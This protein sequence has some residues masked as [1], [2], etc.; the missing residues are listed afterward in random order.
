MGSDSKVK[1][2]G[3]H[4]S[5]ESTRLKVLEELHRLKEKRLSTPFPFCEL[6]CPFLTICSDNCTSEC[7]L[8]HLISLN[9]ESPID[10]EDE[11]LIR[12]QWD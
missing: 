8:S 6:N 10:L 4:H 7:I 5:N 12:I 1:Y 11:R 3:L 2:R 9:T